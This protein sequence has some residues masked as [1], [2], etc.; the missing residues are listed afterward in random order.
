V[1]LQR[2]IGSSPQGPL[3]LQRGGSER[4]TSIWR[5]R[6]DGRRKI[7]SLGEEVIDPAVNSKKER[8][9]RERDNKIIKI[10]F[11]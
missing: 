3:R 11:I 2:A 8:R 4:D 5:S 9:G 10:I 7:S 6:G 1:Y